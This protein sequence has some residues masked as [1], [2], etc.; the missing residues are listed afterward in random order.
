MHG[1]LTVRRAPHC[2]GPLEIQRT[3]ERM[4][5][6]MNLGRTRPAC[7]AYG[8]T[9]FLGKSHLRKPRTRAAF[10]QGLT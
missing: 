5:P 3:W 7:G 4:R 1:E 8:R 2:A 6:A 10:A 9:Y